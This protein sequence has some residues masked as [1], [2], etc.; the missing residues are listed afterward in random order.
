MFDLRTVADGQAD[1][2]PALQDIIDAGGPI[3]MPPGKFRLS[4]PLRDL[5][6]I[7]TCGA[8][9]W[10]S[11]IRPDPGVPA[12]LLHS[13]D[14][15]TYRDFSISYATP[16]RNSASITLD[17]PLEDCE[18]ASFQNLGFRNHNIGLNFLSVK[19]GSMLIEATIRSPTLCSGK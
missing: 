9:R 2:A 10:K 19:T 7:L 16:E 18:G 17:S 1:A 3:V 11:D 13:R 8:G 15:G 5:S 12:F 6:G 14:G 4:R